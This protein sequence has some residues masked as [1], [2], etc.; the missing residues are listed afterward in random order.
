MP[1][2]T[3]NLGRRRLRP[4]HPISNRPATS[5]GDLPFAPP[6]KKITPNPGIELKPPLNYGKTWR[7]SPSARLLRRAACA[8]PDG[9]IPGTRRRLAAWIEPTPSVAVRWTLAVRSARAVCEKYFSN[10]FTPSGQRTTPPSCPWPSLRKSLGY[11][12]HTPSRAAAVLA[13][14]R[15]QRYA[16]P[17][18]FVA[19]RR[20]DRIASRDDCR[21]GP[22]Q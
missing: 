4:R 9:G 20:A 6:D 11:D 5:P 15:L 2:N 18:R 19:T 17:V 14:R 21:A 1:Q 22:H 12:H 3:R 13:T 8:Q 7:G 10:R 16:F